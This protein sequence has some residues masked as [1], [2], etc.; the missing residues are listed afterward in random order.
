MAKAVLE[1]AAEA[2]AVVVCGDV[3]NFGYGLR[4]VCEVLSGFE[5]EVVVVPGNCDLPRQVEDVCE[6]FG[7]TYAHGRLVKVGDVKVAGV[8]GSTRTPFATPFELSEDEIAG[9]LSGFSGIDDLVLATH[10]PPH[11]T[12]VDKV[13][14]GMH[15]G[16]K[17]IREFIERE[18][19]PLCLCG[20]VHERGGEE[21]RLGE[22]RIVNVARRG[23]LLEL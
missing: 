6:E 20:H 15:V 19:P 14:S 1:A 9:L 21:D 16:S 18:R 3:S 4:E 11:G 10:C 13:F 2:D 22:T 5:G 12:K 8:G 7:F 23:S 17:A